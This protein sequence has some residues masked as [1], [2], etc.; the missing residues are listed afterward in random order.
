[1]WPARNAICLD[2]RTALPDGHACH[3][4]RSL[5][6]PAGREAL[7]SE[8]WG[9]KS[10]REAARAGAYGGS[11]ASLLDGCSSCDVGDVFDPRA[12]LVLVVVF[13]AIFVLRLAW[14]LIA[15]LLRRR[16]QR[17]RARGASC[18]N[19]RFGRASACGTIRAGASEP[20]PITGEPCVAFAAELHYRDRVMLRD[21]ATVGFEVELDTGER[22]AIAPGLCRLDTD[23]AVRAAPCE[24]YVKTLDP[25]RQPGDDFDPL[26]GDELRVAHLRVGDRVELH[27]PLILEPSAETGYRDAH[28]LVTDGVP[29]LRALTS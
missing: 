6:D 12:L 2:C 17:L 28:L 1:M 11:G 21:G 19:V 22:V 5:A 25:Q 13:V 10:V 8:V 14:R 27:G 4:V 15:E 9:S 24:H 18:G 7:L 29:C 3:R 26:P 23:A 16:R 20:D